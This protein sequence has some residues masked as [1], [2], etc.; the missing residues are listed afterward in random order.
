[1]VDAGRVGDGLKGL[2][3][4]PRAFVKQLDSLLL[5]NN[6]LCEVTIMLAAFRILLYRIQRAPP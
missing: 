2:Q 4:M 5:S 1:M 3:R 6:S